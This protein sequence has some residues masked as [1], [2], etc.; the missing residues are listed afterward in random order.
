[1]AHSEEHERLAV[2]GEHFLLS[3]WRLPQQPMWLRRPP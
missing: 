1:V 3:G 2:L